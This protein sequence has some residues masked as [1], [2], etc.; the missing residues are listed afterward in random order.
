MPLAATAP[1]GVSI[2]RTARR[3]RRQRSHHGAWCSSATPRMRSCVLNASKG[4][5]AS[6]H[7]SAS[8]VSIGRVLEYSST[9]KHCMAY[10]WVSTVLCME[11][12]HEWN[13]KYSTLRTQSCAHGDV[14]QSALAYTVRQLKLPSACAVTAHCGKV[15]TLHQNSAIAIGDSFELVRPTPPAARRP[16]AL[17]ET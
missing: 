15:S 7:S 6:R 17:P 13:Y 4:S 2:G 8:Y 11:I 10:R 3:P 16:P 9:G 12:D 5:L 1:T 14:H